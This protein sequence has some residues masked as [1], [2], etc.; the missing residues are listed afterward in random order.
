MQEA[1]PAK[2]LATSLLSIPDAARRAGVSTHAIRR[3]I[4]DGLLPAT[5]DGQGYVIAEEALTAYLGNAPLETP[6]ATDQPPLAIVPFP[7]AER[8]TPALPAE[9]T[10]FIGREQERTA[11]RGLLERDDVRLVTLT[12]PGGVGK[13]RLAL[14]MAADLQPRYPDGVAFVPLAAISD[15]SLVP[16][17]IAQAL[18]IRSGED[19]DPLERL[20]HFLHDRTMLLVL[21]NFE[22]ILDAALVLAALLRT[23]P[24]LTLLVTSRAPLR[25]TGEHHFPVPPLAVPARAAQDVL[26]GAA[27][28]EIAGNDAVRLFVDRAE[29][30]GS[31]FA[32]SPANGAAVAAICQRAD[33]LPLAIEL[34]AARTAFL[35]PSALLQRLDPRLP[36]LSGGP[37]DQPGRLRTMHDAIAWSYDLLSPDERAA[38]RRLAVFVGGC[39]IPAAEAVLGLSSA[40]TLAMVQ[41]LVD[42]AVLQ[43]TPGPAGQPRLGMLETIREF[44][45]QALAAHDEES[46]TRDAHAARYLALAA[47][48][49]PQLAGPRQVYWVSVL[50]ADLAN[51]RAA[52]DWL[53]AQGRT[54]D[55]M[56]L[57]GDMG[58]FWSA[59]PYLEEARIRL[60]ALIHAPDAANYPAE[61][62]L[63]LATAGDVADWQSDQ[64]LAREYFERALELYRDLGNQRRAGSMLR[65]LGSSA[66]DRGEP[67]LAISLLHEAREIA[68]TLDDDWEQAATTNLLGVAM[69]M[70]GEFARSVEL[71]R[72][73]GDIW[74]TMQDIG[75]MPPALAS[76]AWSSLQAHDLPQAAG[77]YAEALQFALAAD[78]EWYVAWCIEGAGGIAC[79]RGEWERGTSLLAT[80]ET[81]HTRLGLRHRPHVTVIDDRLIASARQRLGPN[82][83]AAAWERGAATPLADA[84]AEA[85]EL[86]ASTARDTATGA[87]ERHGLTRREGEVLRLICQGKSDRE[88]AEVLF[89]SRATASKHVAAILAKL[90]VQT[91]TSAAMR[92]RELGIG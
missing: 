60:H 52:T 50:E 7:V 77:A 61:L 34:A 37:R 4:Q 91:R 9:L 3:A 43:R 64:T 62:A 13:T 27:L 40:E 19:L 55:A 71:H 51:I 86:F 87:P 1:E 80:G 16:A 18:H 23:C 58:W 20:Q 11:L 75:H 85:Q 32:L 49:G 22:Q 76:Q 83:F 38:F 65:G 68:A 15:V 24:A 48:A 70:I 57:M 74:L 73:A 54:G 72:A 12:G 47:E 2:L 84:V 8:T 44:G 28:A 6:E 56:R 92:A 31:G 66:I 53:V 5:R 41:G 21:D 45:Q 79:Q 82:A 90:D 36:M 78:D 29:A 14:R 33:G 42:Q 17:T 89:I 46:A 26:A 67:N 88:I 35:S 63:V 59:A 69:G 81:R 39:D 30:T 10:L 25:L